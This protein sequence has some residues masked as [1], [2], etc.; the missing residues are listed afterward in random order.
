M[1]FY[2]FE[3]SLEPAAH[4]DILFYV[5]SGGSRSLNSNLIIS[6]LHKEFLI[7][8]PNALNPDTSGDDNIMV[9]F[10]NFSKIS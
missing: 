9:K 6:C 1:L 7:L 5:E 10:A 8:G 4:N 2:M 3:W